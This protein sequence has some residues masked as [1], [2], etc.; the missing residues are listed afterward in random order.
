MTGGL[1]NWRGGCTALA[2]FLLLWTAMYFIAFMAAL[3]NDTP[4]AR[5]VLSGF[6]YAALVANP[7]WGIPLAYIAGSYALRFR[8]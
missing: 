1:A 4:E 5:L 7:V 2:L 6:E 8:D 3:G